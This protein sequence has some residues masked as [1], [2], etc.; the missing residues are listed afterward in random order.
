MKL[1][2]I[3]FILFSVSNVVFAQEDTVANRIML[4]NGWSL[5]PP[6]KS[7][8]LGDLPLNLVVSPT[9]KYLAV[10]NNGQSVQSIQLI[11]P[12]NNKMLSEVIIPISWLGL[13]FS[14]DEKY[15]YA[16]GGNDNL[17]VQYRISNQLTTT[18][19][20]KTRRKMARKNFSDRYSDR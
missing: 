6:G 15:L 12:V 3:L 11:D 9:K 5:T 17:I 16:S 1:L 20:R 13:A 18:A 7:I 14:S 2:F 19:V 10:T 8:P 4:P